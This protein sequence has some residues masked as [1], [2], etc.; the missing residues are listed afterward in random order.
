[1][2]VPPPIPVKRSILVTVVAW[3]F[4]GLSTFALFGL[5]LESLLLPRVFLPML[6]QQMASASGSTDFSPAA[7]WLFDHVVE[8]CHGLLLI[9]ALHLIAAISLLRRKDWGRKL[10]L[11]M[12]GFDVLYQL[13]MAA[14]QW[15]VVGP[16][17]H[18][19]MQM[20]FGPGS[21][22]LTSAHLSPQMQAAQAAQL[23]Q[24]LPMMDS[25]MAVM[26]VFGVIS[27]AVFIMLF[28]WIIRRLC[29]ESIRRE[30]TAPSTFS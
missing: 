9:A 30:F 19:M 7:Q 11:M 26:R 10:M 2:S 23:V 5:L 22:A 25:M 1:M 6:H 14:M 21:Q 12:L 8:L 29:S 3:I 18:A 13:A 17:Q 4:I 16:M 15:W 24:M 28:G 20:Q 27:A